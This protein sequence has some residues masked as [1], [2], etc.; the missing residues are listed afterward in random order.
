MNFAN[1]KCHSVLYQ[2]VWSAIPDKATRRHH[3]QTVSK[4]SSNAINHTCLRKKISP[5][6]LNS[7]PWLD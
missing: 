4:T 3:S 5:L 2:R 7:T 1:S 6:N